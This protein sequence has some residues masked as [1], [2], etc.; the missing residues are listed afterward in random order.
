MR[1]RAGHN[2]TWGRITAAVLA[3][4]CLLSL[5][6]AG[7]ASAV[8]SSSTS[9]SIDET[10]TIVEEIV[11]AQGSEKYSQEELTAFINA[12]LE[13]YNAD[14]DEAAISLDSCLIESGTV[15]IR[16]TYNSCADYADFN[17]MVCFDGT[18]QEAEAAG[19]EI[20][21][22]W[23]DP[24]GAIGDKEIIRERD[25][26]WKIFIVSEAIDVKVPDKI[27]YASE[28]VKITGRLTAT[29][30]TVMNEAEE[31]A[32]E[33]TEVHPLATVADRFAYIIYK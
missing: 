8:R 17:Q 3:L 12:Q 21:R 23:L 22:T 6:L 29:V 1:K 18:L 26:E 14:K 7:C 33:Q 25:A 30:K 4:V 28:N 13:Q 9:L 2:F 5:G 32:S 24:E 16:M 19:Y 10:G 15:K 11:E 31:E 27:L 20:E